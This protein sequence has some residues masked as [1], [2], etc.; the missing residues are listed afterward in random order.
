MSV[1]LKEILVTVKYDS[2]KFLYLAK[3]YAKK[4][5]L[6]DAELFYLS[7]FSHNYG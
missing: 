4:G 5:K 3:L 7:E 2:T 1:T 6:L